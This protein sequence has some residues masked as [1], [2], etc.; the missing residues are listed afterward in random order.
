MESWKVYEAL[1]KAF[2]A[3]GAT[4]IFGM[5]GDGNMHWRAA[6]TAHPEVHVYEARHEGAALMMADGWARFSGRPGVCMVTHGPGLTQAATSLVA[7]SRSL[8]PIVVFAGEVAE[9]D[10]ENPQ[11]YEQRRF[12]DATESGFVRMGRPDA[13]FDVVRTAFYMARVES[14]PIVLSLPI[15]MQMMEFEGSDEYE[16]S[17]SLYPA[18]RPLQPERERLLEAV[19]II[20]GSRKPVIIAGRGA[21]AADAGSAILQ[22]AE[23]IGAL[24]AT[25]VLAKGYLAGNDYHAGVAGLFSTAAAA[26]MFSE[27]DCVIGVGASLNKYTLESGYLFQQARFVQI[28]TKPLVITGT[29]RVADCYI[30]GDAGLTLEALE[31]LLHE[32]GVRSTGYRTPETLRVLAADIDPEEFALDAGTLDPRKVSDALDELLPPDLGLVLGIGHFFAFPL[33]HLRRAHWPLQTTFGFGAIGQGIGTAIGAAVAAKR[34][35]AVI[36]GD[37]STMMHVQE[38]DTAARYGLPL[39]VVVMNDEGLGAEYQKLSAHHLDPELAVI[40]S[41]DLAKVAEGFGLRGRIA[42]TVDAL[43]DAVREFLANPGPMLVDVRISRKVTSLPYRRM[44]FGKHV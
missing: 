15:D 37:A 39:L 10:P 25:T 20:A 40:G 43:R 42:T 17:T 36:E 8:T 28:D 27:A 16:T 5:M 22:I 13:A 1:A 44:L 4:A 32:R 18:A 11:F 9:S 26:E 31:T 12:A 34:P 24:L 6:L 41:P 30:R 35:L 33:L 19:D 38:L 21:I 2:A 29:G 7:A 23:R 14:R 3:E